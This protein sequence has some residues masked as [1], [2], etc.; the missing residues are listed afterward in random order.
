MSGFTRRDVLRAGIS[1]VVIGATA[2]WMVPPS[3]VAAG[4][5]APFIPYGADSF[6]KSTV[7]GAPVNAMRTSA[8]K[9]FMKT[10]VDQQAIPYPRIN[11]LG[12]SK[13][14]TAYAMG[15]A[16]DPIWRLTGTVPKGASILETQ[17]FHA[18]DWLINQ[19]SGTN[20]APFCVIDRGSGF[21]VFAGNAV[22]NLSKHTISVLA[23]GITYHSS[24]GL[25]ARNPRSRDKRNSTSRGRISE[26]MV[27]RR[28]LVDYGIA[29]NTGLGH[30][31]QLFLAA[32]DANDGFCHP[33][34]GCES[35]HTE[36]WGAEGERL[37]IRPDV[38][39]SKRGL[40]PFGLVVART[41]Q[42]HGCYIGDNSGSSSALK[43]EQISTSRNP[44]AG[45]TATQDALAGHITW[46]DFV[47]IDRGWQ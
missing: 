40:T 6:L 25:D 9:A 22:G 14:G 44:W 21:T 26:A 30:T 7:A 19:F 10:F 29:N 15:Q 23:A 39:L 3:A 5:G 16:S 12:T 45:L 18:P 17:G 42:Q 35:R 46:D 33:M 13:W 8:F 38:D 20:D 36:G 34:V 47:V 24:N 2:N 43:A 4:S 41:L 32:T 27:I 37:A 11:G 28:D 31:L 1:A